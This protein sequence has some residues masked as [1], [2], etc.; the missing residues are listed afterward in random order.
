MARY[1]KTGVV[2]G[3]VVKSDIN[4]Q[5]GLIETA[6]A[7]SL[8]RKGDLPNSMSVDIDMDSNDI[9][10]VNSIDIQALNYKGDAVIPSDLVNTQLPAVANRNI[11]Y[12]GTDG[13]DYKWKRFPITDHS[14]EIIA[15]RGF[16]DVGFQNTLLSLSMSKEQGADSL[17]CDIQISSDGVWY[18]FHDT[19]VDSLT[20]GTGT[21]TALTSTYIDTLKYDKGVGTPFDELRIS[22]LDDL[23]TYIKEERMVL[24]PEIKKVRT[25]ADVT[26]LYNVFKDADVLDLIVVQSAS[27]TRLDIL[28]A[29]DPNIRLAYLTGETNAT[30]LLGYMKDGD[31]DDVV[32]SQTLFIADPALPQTILENGYGVT[33]YTINSRS[34]AT[35]MRQLGVCRLISDVTV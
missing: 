1:T 19:T 34:D 24:Y 30:T 33:A 28:R 31:Y 23:L 12:L 2:T 18:L 15:H 8:S 13:T 4:V 9:L 3:D 17:E 11:D 16:A 26:T 27:R 20:D 5:L 32:M 35:A 14:R 29:L 25:D 6:I 7:D 21:F 22:K 10:N